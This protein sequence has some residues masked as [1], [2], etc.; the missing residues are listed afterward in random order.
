MALA[1]A[2]LRS[3]T[4]ASGGHLEIKEYDLCLQSDDDTIPSYSKLAQIGQELASARAKACNVA[5]PNPLSQHILDEAG[6]VDIKV[7]KFKV[8]TNTWPT[9]AAL[10]EL[11]KYRNFDQRMMLESAL[12]DLCRIQGWNEEG[13]RELVSGAMNELNHRRIHAYHDL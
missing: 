11:G 12:G 4:L 10:Q 13:A 1:K 5:N 9:D 7:R 6:F 2:D 3:R 8:P